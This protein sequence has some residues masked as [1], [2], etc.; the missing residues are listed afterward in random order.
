MWNLK[1]G[2]DA[3]IYITETDYGQGEQTC[4]SWEVGVGSGMD[5]QFR[6]FGRKLLYFEWIGNGALLYSEVCV[7][8]SLCCTT[9]IEE[10][11]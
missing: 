7:I 11:L 10:T 2:T 3:P 4:G 6:V 5:R 9:E 1:Y 8:R